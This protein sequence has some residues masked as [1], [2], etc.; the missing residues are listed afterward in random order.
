V[1]SISVPIPGEQHPYGVLSAHTAKRRVFSRDDIHFLQMVA[2]VLATAHQ[3]SRAEEALRLR[4]RAIAAAPEGIVITDPRQPDNPII[5]VNAGFERLTGYS[6]A[7]VRGRNCRFLRGPDTDLAALAQIRQAIREE[8]ECT[9]QILNYRKDGTPFWNL[10][11]ISPVRDTYGRPIYFVGV[12][13]DITERQRTEFER[14]KFV[15]LVENSSDFIGM[16]D[17]EGKPFFINP[18]GCRLVGLDG[19]EAVAAT[20]IRDYCTGATWAL[21]RDIALPIARAQGAWQGEGQ[22]RHFKTGRP[23]DVEMNI[24][25]IRH[26]QTDQPLCLAG[27]MHDITE[28][29]KVERMKREFIS[30]VSHELR[31]PLTS[32]CGSLGLVKGGVTG[33]L[34]MQAKGL[35]E[36][37]YR[38]S[39]RLVRLVNDI[40]DMDRME[41]G[42]LAFA[43]RPMELLP[44]VQAAMDLNRAYAE[45]LGVQL[46]LN[47]ALP[48]ARAYIDPDRIIQV[49]TNLLSNAAKF[50]PRQGIV[51]VSMARCGNCIRLAVTD[52]GPGIPE[53]FKI[54]IFD[55][56][57]QADAS[58]SRRRGGTGLGLHIAKAIV[59]QSGG[60]IGFET[61][62]EGGTTFYCDLPEWQ[63][64][65]ALVSDAHSESSPSPAPPKRLA[66]S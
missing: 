55:K 1:S 64:A 9:V 14:Q 61:T 66:Q 7:E 4:D 23:I 20:E 38:N 62:P 27:V 25:W 24:F 28:R 49:L 15:S 50:S 3:R 31:T 35:I 29:K 45:S 59:E 26:P 2:H 65:G 21:L 32:I 36:I 40:L 48:G 33:E 51:S 39:E 44:L 18:A 52:R 8:R 41:S 19:L 58:D 13:T 37:A 46:V 43:P 34:P 30:T 57:A 12:Q 10:M 47:Q 16:A 17:L 63:E 60:T 5:Y 56:F 54:R 11:S 53:E 22:L 6:A 42:R